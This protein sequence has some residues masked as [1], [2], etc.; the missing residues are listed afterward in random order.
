MSSYLDF[1]NELK[2]KKQPDI[3]QINGVKVS[4]DN[5]NN[6]AG[7]QFNLDHS[8][9]ALF[10]SQLKNDDII[11][12]DNL[13]LEL[14]NADVPATVVV[15]EKKK[16]AKQVKTEEQQAEQEEHAKQDE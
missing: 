6:E 4:F 7:V 8:S 11:N 1:L 16:R 15:V 13:I 9:H 2:E 3:K 14:N 12:N 5:S 10:I